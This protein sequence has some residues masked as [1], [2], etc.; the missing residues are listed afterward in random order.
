MNPGPAISVLRHEAGGRCSSEHPLG[1]LPRVGPL[2]PRE[3]HGEVGGE[4]AVAGVAGPLSTNSTP[5]APSRAATRA[6]SARSSSLTRP[7]PFCEA[8]ELDGLGRG[9][10]VGL[11]RFVGLRSRRA[12]T[13]RW[14][15]GLGLARPLAVLAVVRDVE[16]AALEDQ[17]G[18][19]GDLARGRLAAHR[20][21]GAGLLGDPL[22]LLE[23]MPLG[24]LILVGRHR[25]SL[26]R[27]NLSYCG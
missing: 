19:A 2:A 15:L 17:P 27:P 3:H 5:S 6:S 24:A 13:R 11:G 16:A 23:L 21:L 26:S 7:R 22:E 25:Y 8:L 4:V 14:L 1:G 9:L 12:S 18:A 10:G 20:T